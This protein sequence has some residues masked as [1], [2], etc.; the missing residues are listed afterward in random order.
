[1]NHRLRPVTPEAITLDGESLTLEQLSRLGS[2]Q[3]QI[4]LADESWK[5]LQ[6]TR[7]IVENLS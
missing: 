2:G 6:A 1:M 3:G 5:R 4:S 7:D